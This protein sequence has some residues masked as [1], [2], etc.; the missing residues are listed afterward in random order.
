M[1]TQRYVNTQNMALQ[2]EMPIRIRLQVSGA[3]IRSITAA[4]MA[5]Y[6]DLSEFEHGFII[7]T[8]EMRHSISE[9]AMHLGFF[10]TTISRVHHE[11]Q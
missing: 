4:T 7:G 11:Y 10:H 3:S 5:G 6:H 9:I 1:Q 2:S 8:R